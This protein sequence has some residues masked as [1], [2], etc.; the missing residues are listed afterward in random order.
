MNRQFIEEEIE[1]VIWNY[2]LQFTWAFFFQY[3]KIILVKQIISY[4]AFDSLN[5]INWINLAEEQFGNF[6]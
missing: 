3:L 2:N 5:W 4:A 1:M 6:S